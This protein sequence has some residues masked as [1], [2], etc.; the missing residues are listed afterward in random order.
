MKKIL[1]LLNNNPA[2]AT[3]YIYNSDKLIF[4]NVPQIYYNNSYK[5]YNPP[6]N[7]DEIN[8]VS[9][10]LKKIINNYHSN[11]N[12]FKLNNCFENSK[13]LFEHLKKTYN[14]KF[15]SIKIVYGFIKREVSK[16]TDINGESISKNIIVH[17]WHVWNYINNFL[18]DITLP[19]Y[20]LTI[21]IDEELEW[22]DAQKHCFIIPP[23]KTE[24]FGLE[25]DDYNKFEQNFRDTFQV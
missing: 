12:E 19:N 9:E 15:D 8:L 14:N 1:D 24:Y 18:V 13:I 6:Q 20:G 5:R 7:N 21:N 4:S 17:D 11:I 10:S 22:G 23:L 3:Y 16:E 25:F 2:N